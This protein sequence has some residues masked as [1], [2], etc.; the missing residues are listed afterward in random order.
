MDLNAYRRCRRQADE[1]MESSSLL[2][3]VLVSTRAGDI[4]GSCTAENS[5]EQNGETD[6]KGTSQP[7]VIMDRKAVG[8]TDYP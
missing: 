3:P 2:L 7:T 8:G 4:A 1:Q 5:E 6:G